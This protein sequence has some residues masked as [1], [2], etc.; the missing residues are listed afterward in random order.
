MELPYVE[1]IL[2][3]KTRQWILNQQSTSAELPTRVWEVNLWILGPHGQELPANIFEKCT[4]RLHPTFPQPILTMTEPPFTLKQ[5]GWGEF[6]YPIQCTFLHG[7]GKVEVLHDLS[8]EESSY[9]SDIRIKVPIHVPGLREV[10][11]TSGI[12]PSV[13]GTNGLAVTLTAD[14]DNCIKK[15]VA[16]DEELVTDVVNLI[17]HH[18]GVIRQIEKLDLADQFVF[19]LHQ[20]PENLLK[21]V[22]HFIDEYQ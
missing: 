16:G 11:K 13:P 20:L 14:L 10:L 21:E 2:R 8:F 22:I 6:S 18:P 17:L 19:N 9:H 15:L 1:R 5:H 4:Y 7:C 12:V 3:I